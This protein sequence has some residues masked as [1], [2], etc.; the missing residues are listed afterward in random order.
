V[1]TVLSNETRKLIERARYRYNYNMR[2]L[3]SYYK[4][5]AKVHPD[6]SM[7]ESFFIPRN[8]NDQTRDLMKYIRLAN[9]NG[10]VAVY[11]R[12]NREELRRLKRWPQSVEDGTA[13]SLTDFN[14]FF[15]MMVNQHRSESTNS[16]DDDL[17]KLLGELDRAA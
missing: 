11:R 8:P 3:A 14:D 9:E 1:R 6:P 15:E 2:A 4:R 10:T 13:I 7:T 5:G 16:E 12:T 17:G